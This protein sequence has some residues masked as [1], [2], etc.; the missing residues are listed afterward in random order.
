MWLGLGAWSRV[1]QVGTQGTAGVLGAANWPRVCR[2][3]NW[4]LGEPLGEDGL[5]ICK[6][7]GQLM[8]L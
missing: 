6:N 5:G 1:S 4:G 8:E 7:R 2:G 3:S